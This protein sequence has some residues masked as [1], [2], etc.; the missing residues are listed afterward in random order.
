VKIAPAGVKISSRS[1]FFTAS[2]SSHGL[3]LSRPDAPRPSVVAMDVVAVLI[4]LIAFAA[5][6]ATIVLVDRT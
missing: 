3:P 4:S 5:I 6:Y 1:H 2:V